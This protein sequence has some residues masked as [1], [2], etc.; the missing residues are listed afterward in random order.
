MRIYPHLTVAAGNAV[1]DRASLLVSLVAGGQPSSLAHR[2]S[3]VGAISTPRRQPFLGVRGTKLPGGEGR[4][5]TSLGVPAL[6]SFPVR[7][8]PKPRLREGFDSRSPVRGLRDVGAGPVP[9][10]GRSARRRWVLFRGSKR[11]R[12]TTWCGLGSAE[13]FGSSA[14]FSQRIPGLV[15]LTESRRTDRFDAIQKLFDTSEKSCRESRR[16]LLSEKLARV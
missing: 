5:G 16:I 10:L 7:W 1:R 14:A 6:L 13:V 15:I 2:G 12:K 9:T 3:I 8:S 11:L 4:Q